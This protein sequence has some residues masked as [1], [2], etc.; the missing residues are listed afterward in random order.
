M[1]KFRSPPTKSYNSYWHLFLK[2]IA[3]NKFYN[4]TVEIPTLKKQ[5]IQV[6]WGKNYLL[7]LISCTKVFGFFFFIRMCLGVCFKVLKEATSFF[8]LSHSNIQV[9][10]QQTVDA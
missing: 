4:E 7:L 9:D 2:T 1:V 5:Q 8:C 3:E 6:K 10:E